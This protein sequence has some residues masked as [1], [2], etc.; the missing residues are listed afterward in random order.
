MRGEDRIAVA[1]F[2]DGASNTGSFDESLNMAAKWNLPVVFF[3]ENNRYGL[4]V[5]VDDHLSTQSVV[6][7][8]S[9]Y[10]MSG[11]SVFG[12]DMQEVYESMSEAVEKVRGGSGPVLLEAETY[13]LHGFSTTDTGGYQIEKE[14]EYWK[15]RDPILRA[16]RFLMD[17]K[18]C[19]EAEIAEQR[20]RA[21][22]EIKDAVEYA[23]NASYPDAVRIPD[24]LFQG[25]L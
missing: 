7:R 10:G 12:N 20:K 11:I 4:T 25:A 9:A 15:D 1:F 22:D 3:C 6:V 16:E 23:L 21:F 19:T 2:G 14:M 24:D 18:L 13:R 8:A 17:E 5:H